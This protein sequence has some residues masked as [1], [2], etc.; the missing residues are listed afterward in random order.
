MSS[1]ITRV[2]YACYT[3]NVTMGV[4][5]NVSPMLFMTFRHQYDISYTLLGLLVLINFVTQLSV[6]LI[7]S[8]FSH[9]FN[10][11]LTVKLTPAIAAVGLVIYALAPWLFPANV[12]A[13]LLIGTVIFSAASG[14]AEV[15]ISPVIAALPADD[16]DRE[17]SKLHSIYAWGSV[18]VIL[19]STLYLF[20]FTG[21][22]WQYLVLALT[23]IPLLSASLFAS[24]TL[25][26]LDTP[27]RVFGALAM[28]KNGRLWLCIAA[29]FFGGAAECTMAQWCSGYLEQAL[30]I[31]KLWGDIFGVAVFS[32]ALGTGR[33]LYAKIGRHIH[34]VLLL[35]AIGAAACYLCAIV[36]GLPI[37]GLLACALTGFCVSML[38]PGS[39]IVAADAFP[40]SGVFIY[41]IMAAG[42]D[43]G[44]S[45][46]PQ[47]VGVITDLVSGSAFG[48]ERAQALGL[49]AEQFGMKMGMLV[50]FLFS[51]AG[52]VVYAL[53]WKKTKR[54]Q[55]NQ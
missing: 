13:G 7:F 45:V 28:F 31:P 46:S 47:L 32:V 22:H 52:V 8:F 51:L 16:P 21:A 23:L 35:G 48:L 55:L 26:A 27:E 40:T 11:P 49:G 17:M 54:R 25:P 41:A 5:A 39:L 30:G 1:N 12:Y 4:I 44:A 19:V 36:S 3:T 42:G 14:L 2:K 38:W 15:L 29:I 34:R 9:K 18:F 50:G 33:T 24:A 37:I 10:I 53:L 43:L 20:A 6:D